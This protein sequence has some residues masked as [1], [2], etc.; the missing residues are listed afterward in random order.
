MYGMDAA[1]AAPISAFTRYCHYQYGVVYI[2]ITGG[3]GGS[4]RLRNSVDDDGGRGVP[5]Q[6]VGAQRMVLIRAQDPRNKAISC[7]GQPRSASIQTKGGQPQ[8][9]PHPHCQVQ[10]R[11]F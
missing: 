11:A 4:I 9:H 10:E 2:A 1:G 3:Q 7:I 8:P 5:K 6:R